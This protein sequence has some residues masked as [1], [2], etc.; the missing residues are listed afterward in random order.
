MAAENRQPSGSGRRQSLTA[1]GAGWA[2]RKAAVTSLQS[3]PR[4]L[5]RRSAQAWNLG[6]T[7]SGRP[8][9]NSL[10]VERIVPRARARRSRAQP[11]EQW[12]LKARPGP[13]RRPRC[14]KR[15]P[16][17]VTGPCLLWPRR[18]KARRLSRQARIARRFRLP[19]R[20]AARPRGSGLA[21]CTCRTGPGPGITGMA[22]LRHRHRQVSRLRQSCPGL[23]QHWPGRSRRQPWRL[24]LP[25]RKA[26]KRRN[27]CRDLTVILPSFPGRW[28]PNLPLVGARQPCPCHPG[29]FH[30]WP[31]ESWQRCMRG[32]MAGP[33][34]PCRRTNLAASGCGSRPTPA[35][36]TA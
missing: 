23:R 20:S 14:Q 10:Q 8:P 1:K 32:P 12:S 25:G 29:H 31:Q 35:T 13:R 16:F 34:L 21:S 3:V 22:L 33:R 18:P 15:V 2:R 11:P 9:R 24:L 30:S 5:Q 28:Q 27:I 17:A 26:L 6:R 36:L 4:R 7:R 19:P